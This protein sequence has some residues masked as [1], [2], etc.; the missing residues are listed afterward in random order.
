MSAVG[1]IDCRDRTNEFHAILKSVARQRDLAALSSPPTTVLNQNAPIQRHVSRPSMNGLDKIAAGGGPLNFN[2]NFPNSGNTAL[3]IFAPNGN[4]TAF[5]KQSEFT[6]A[7]QGVSAGICRVTENLEHLAK[8]NHFY[9]HSIASLPYQ[10]YHTMHRARWLFAIIRLA[11][12]DHECPVFVWR[13]CV[14]AKKQSLFN[15][16]VREINQLTGNTLMAS[17]T[18]HASPDEWCCV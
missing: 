6:K 18:V 2:G 10:P 1:V 13:C 8:C 9:C 16:P 3:P 7:A 17:F 11:A 12:F 4:G 15:D 14:V 5:Q